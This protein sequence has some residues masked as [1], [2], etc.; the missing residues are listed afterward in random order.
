MDSTVVICYAKA[1][2]LPLDQAKSSV[3]DKGCMMELPIVAPAP[4]VSNHAG[5]FRDLFDNP[6]QFR[7]V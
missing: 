5:V 4:M 6:C 1:S 3:K 2:L 7:H